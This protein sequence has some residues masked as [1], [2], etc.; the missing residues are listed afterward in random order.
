HPRLAGFLRCAST[1]GI[2]GCR[3]TSRLSA[4]YRLARKEEKSGLPG[5]PGAAGRPERTAGAGWSRWNR[6]RRESDAEGGDDD[7]GEARGCGS[8]VAG[9]GSGGAG[10]RNDEMLQLHGAS[11]RRLS[12][13]LLALHAVQLLCC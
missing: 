12:V 4:S 8:P 2:F 5:S 13:L 3:R 10:P 11:L 6:S 1:H 7:E 9:G